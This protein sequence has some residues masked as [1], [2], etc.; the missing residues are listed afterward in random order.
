MPRPEKPI[1]LVGPI[2]ELALDLRELRK[3]EGLTVRE[4]AERANYSASVIAEA[5]GGRTLP[6]WAVT[7]AYVRACGQEP[8][9]W[10]ARWVRAFRA[11]QAL[12]EDESIRPNP[13][14]LREVSSSA[15]FAEALQRL[16]GKRTLSDLAES[17]GWSESRLKEAFDER[18]RISRPGLEAMLVACDVPA[19]EWG[20]WQAAHLRAFRRETAVREVDPRRLST[21]AELVN[22]LDAL[23]EGRSYAALD[24]AVRPDRL[25]SSTISDLLRI[26]R[27]TPETLDL[28]LRACGVP[29]NQRGAWRD[30]YER[31]VNSA[32]VAIRKHDRS[33]PPEDSVRVSDANSRRLGVHAAIDVPEADGPQPVYIERDS[34]N[35][36]RALVSRAAEQGGLVVITGGSGTGKTRSAFEAVRAVVPNWWL[37]HPRD[38]DHLREVAANNPSQLVV[39]LDELQLYLRGP[40]ALD[41]G[42]VRALLEAGAVIMATT[43]PHYYA[44]Y[45]APAAPGR[46]D[47][48]G[49]AREVLKLADV[50]HLNATFSTAELQRAHAA[51][52]GDARIA[53]A[54][55]YR[56]HQLPQM[57]AAAPQL[58]ERWRS[59]DPYASAVLHAALDAT[60]SGENLPLSADLLRQT[61]P[62]Y[63]DDRRRAEASSDW[64]ESALAYTTT[65][66]SG[67]IA[68]LAPVTAGETM[69]Q[70]DG[71]VMADYVVHHEQQQRAAD[72]TEGCRPIE[73]RCFSDS[74]DPP[75]PLVRYLK[76]DSSTRPGSP[77]LWPRPSQLC[78]NEVILGCTNAP[79]SEE[80][81]EPSIALLYASADSDHSSTAVMIKA[82]LRLRHTPLNQLPAE[83]V[84]TLLR[85]LPET[86][87][88]RAT[89]RLAELL[90]EHGRVEELRALAETGDK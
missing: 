18:G 87:D 17:A 65:S 82:L 48:V 9:R 50:V 79:T 72:M 84:I 8:H 37:L 55:R 56:G 2:A 15:E 35:G 81:E 4:L 52:D 61:A 34:D 77:R 39:W 67:G 11:H 20:A 68:L 85:A 40:N 43:W 75:G 36:L 53:T 71:Y 59:A 19:T 74:D 5:S 30:A 41:V 12:S 13:T 32:S 49:T 24:R 70:I 21:A 86:S 64:F 3:R 47:D 33:A 60:L 69:G 25:P 63:C 58:L 23:R 38:A 89:L 45:I 62:K 51:R 90:A 44:G 26:G 7:E 46:L 78:E 22:A 66:L 73:F 28:F 16:A 29:R 1:E 31:L 88:K 14:D 76:P 54:L 57:I 42:T 6:T 10:R 27:A 80:H 83:E